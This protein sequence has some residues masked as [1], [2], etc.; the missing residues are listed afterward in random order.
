[1]HA[2]RGYQEPQ[3]KVGHAV[4]AARFELYTDKAGECRGRLWAANNEIIAVGGA[5]NSKASV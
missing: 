1:M 4:M 5:C 3:Q 2:D